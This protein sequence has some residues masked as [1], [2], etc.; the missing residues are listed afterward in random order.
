MGTRE[1]NLH[2][3]EL[4]RQ[5]SLVPMWEPGS[6]WHLGVEIVIKLFHLLDFQNCSDAVELYTGDFLVGT[7]RNF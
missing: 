6:K 1:N 2:F 4:P 5:F 7:F 3:W